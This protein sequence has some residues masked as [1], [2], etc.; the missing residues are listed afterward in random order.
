MYKYEYIIYGIAEE[1]YEF[2]S[3][4]AD[5]DKHPELWE[6]PCPYAI[7]DDADIRVEKKGKI[8]VT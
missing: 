2:L 5:L 7:P 4:I 3:E 6:E 8:N 1:G